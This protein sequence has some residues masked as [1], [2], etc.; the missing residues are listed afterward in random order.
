[1]E[2][3]ND[4]TLKEEARAKEIEESKKKKEQLS[5][6]LGKQINELE[7]SMFIK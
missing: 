1:M 3:L 2:Y 4:Q 5:E 6:R 7:V